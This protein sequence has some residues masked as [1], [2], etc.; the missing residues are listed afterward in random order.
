MSATALTCRSCTAGGL[1]EILSLGFT[2]LAN[3]LVKREQLD[4]PEPL[5]PLELVFC[6]SCSLVQ[7]TETVPQEQLFRHYLY[8]SSVS[9]TAL[10]HAREA[11][12]RLIQRRRLDG[13]HLVVEIASNDGYLLQWYRRAGVPVLG[14]EPA[15]NVASIAEQR[16]IP[17]LNE[18]FDLHLARRLHA[19]G[20]IADVVHAHN[21]LAHVADLNGFVAGLA[22]ILKHDGV[23][24]V[25]VPYVRPMVEGLE[26]D[27]IYHEHLCYFSLTTLEPLFGRHGLRVVEL[28]QLAIHGGSL[29]LLLAKGGQAAHSVRELR[30]EERAAGVAALPFYS[31]FAARVAEFCREIRGLLAGLK[32]SGRSLAAYGAAAKGSTLL[33][34]CRIGAETLDFLVDRSPLKQGLYT[35][36]T[37]LPILP[38]QA[39]LEQRPDY[40]LLLTWNFAEEILSQQAAYRERGGKFIVPLPELEVL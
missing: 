29:R 12:A 30:A 27:T 10:Q 15:A 21:V 8:L 23:A 9:D 22:L 5:Y 7:I 19:E 4:E 34:Y 37:H 35:P 38:P 16:G 3:R 32:Q 18:F 17:T 11:A 28:E 6:P 31:G 2:P 26:F 40:V 24:V 20:R 39:L 36:G 1:Q 14:I 13:H 33:N 25:E